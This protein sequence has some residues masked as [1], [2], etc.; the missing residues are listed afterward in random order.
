MEAGGTGLRLLTFT[1][2][3]LD[4]SV[5]FHLLCLRESYFLWIG[6]GP[7]VLAN[8]AVAC[9][10][11]LDKHPSSAI[12]MGPALK[13]FNSSLAQRLAKRNGAMFFVSCNLLQHSN[14]LQLFV[15]RRLAQ[16]LQAA[17][18]GHGKG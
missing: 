2:Q 11:K 14:E 12:L 7:P 9:P 6:S 13:E 17:R 10:T 3:F 5:H 16:E 18:L 4:T 8:L 1:D 15:E